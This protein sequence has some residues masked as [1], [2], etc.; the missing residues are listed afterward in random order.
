[1]NWDKH[2]IE[3]ANLPQFY[4]NFSKLIKTGDNKLEHCY[5]FWKYKGCPIVHLYSLF[6]F[7][8]HYP[9]MMEDPILSIEEFI[10]CQPLDQT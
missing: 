6:E 9:A 8:D 10:F 1:M 3:V 4:E 5:C 2:Q 7:L